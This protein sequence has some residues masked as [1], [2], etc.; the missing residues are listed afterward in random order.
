MNRPSFLEGALVALIA[1]V[2]AAV[3]YTGLCLPFPPREALA[4]T[5]AALGLG[6][7]LYLLARSGERAGRVLLGLAWVP[8][9]AAS[10][11][12]VPSAWSQCLVQL[13]L[14]WVV[15]VWC[16]QWTPTA[17]LLDLGLI[18][19]GVAAA[20]WASLH[21]GSLFLAVWSLLLVQALFGAIPARP[22]HR[23]EVDTGPEPF[24]LARRSAE[25]ALRRCAS[26]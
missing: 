23:A 25:G 11:A 13:G 26:S 15:R 7:L 20:L 24:D 6:Y 10:L 2:V 9:T 17:A 22:W 1:A 5:V 18:L 4:L 21:S 19:A 8:V 12:L 3:L 14:V 16:F